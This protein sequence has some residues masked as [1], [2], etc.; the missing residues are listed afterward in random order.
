VIANVK[1]KKMS[2]NLLV[3][4]WS[5][6]YDT[7]SKRK[8]LNAKFSNIKSSFIESGDSPAFGTFDLNSFVSAVSELYPGADEDRPF[9]IELYPKAICFSIPNS[10]AR[11]LIP[12]LGSLATRHHLNGAQC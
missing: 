4:K 5:E 6:D 1:H 8:R 11:E 10:Q 7:P 3:W 9:V 2:E 12:K